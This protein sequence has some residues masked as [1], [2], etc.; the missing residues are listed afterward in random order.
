[1]LQESKD[2][3]IDI[4][5]ERR[6]PVSGLVA[7]EMASESKCGQMVPAMRETGRT[8]EL[9]DLE[10][11][12]T[13]MGIFMKV[14][15]SMTKPMEEEFTFMLTEQDMRVSGWTISS[16]VMEKNLGQM[17][18]SMKV[19]TSQE[20]SMEEVFTVG[21]MD[22]SIMAIGKRTRSRVLALTPG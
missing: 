16:M 15:G 9:K 18:Q 14:T 19:N 2:R 17:A 11:S 13:S 22:L 5:Q 7:S 4:R 1:M 12:P 20:R 3:R 8:I 6:I 10:S 21:T